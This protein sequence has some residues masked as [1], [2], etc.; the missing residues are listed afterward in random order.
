MSPFFDAACFDI[1]QPH[2]VSPISAY[3]RSLLLE[4]LGFF[5]PSPNPFAFRRPFSHLAF[6]TLML[7]PAFAFSRI[8]SAA[9]KRPRWSGCCSFTSTTP[10]A[11]ISPCTLLDGKLTSNTIL[12]EIKEKV[13]A[14]P[15]PPGLAGLCS[16]VSYSLADFPLLLSHFVCVSGVRWE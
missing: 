7:R 6:N 14:L 9:R 5:D 11:S 2:K 8:I 16:L 3:E 13:A 1:P 10:A 12:K 4:S 15:Q